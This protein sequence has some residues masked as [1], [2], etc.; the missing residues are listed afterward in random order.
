MFG[1]LRKFFSDVGLELKKTSWPWDAREKGFRKFKELTDS[2][3][4]VIIAIVLLGAWVAFWDFIM[5]Y[6][7]GFFTKGI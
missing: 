1:S 6:V 7:M 4:V 5:A 2:T 3:V